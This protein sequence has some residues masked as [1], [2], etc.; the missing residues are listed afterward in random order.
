MGLG[1]GVVLLILSLLFGRNL[2]EEGGIDTGM[3][4]TAGGDVAPIN[5][6]PEERAR[7]DLV[8]SVL[9]DAQDTW[10]RILPQHNVQYRDAKL[11][12][13][14]DA[15]QSACGI[16]QAA[17]GPFYCPVDEQVYLDLGFF[18][19]L[20]RRFGAAGDFAQAYVIA[21]EIGHHVQHI[22]GRDAEVRQ[23]QEQRPN[24]ANE[25]SVRL[26]LQADCYAGVW[27]NSTNKRQL[28]DP[29]DIEEGLNAAAAIGD[30]RIQKQ[31]GGRVN[32]ES[33]THGSSAERERWFR[34]GLESG[35]PETCNTFAGAR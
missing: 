33:F 15:T 9:D 25:L 31:S 26:E 35:D 17:M 21:H 24:E 32:R 4:N 34:R 20:N 7:V 11:V 14:R 8:H 23:R 13:F 3:T 29:G 27:G 1:G 5:E 30:D 12:L 10:E 16:G 2:F 19:E 6:T 22:L 18:D 28:L